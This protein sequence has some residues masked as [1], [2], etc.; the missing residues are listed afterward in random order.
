MLW[1]FETPILSTSQHAFVPR[2]SR[3]SNL[4]TLVQMTESFLKNHHQVDVV[5][6]VG[7]FKKTWFWGNQLLFYFWNL[8]A[9]KIILG[10]ALACTMIFI[11]ASTMTNLFLNSQ[12]QLFSCSGIE[13]LTGFLVFYHIKI[14]FVKLEACAIIF[15]TASPVFK[16]MK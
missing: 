8:Y 14:N 2:R 15:S 5:Y 6:T 1:P 7:W 4:L 9:E 12:N 11:T 16:F 3:N 10:K 13:L